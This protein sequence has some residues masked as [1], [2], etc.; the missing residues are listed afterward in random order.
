M[1]ATTV[2]EILD[3]ARRLESL[4]AEHCE[5]LAERSADGNVR[6]LAA[7]L[8]RHYRRLAG[9]LEAFSQEAY[10]R[11]C[12]VPIPYGP[13]ATDFRRLLD[14]DLPADATS[15]EVLDTAMRMDKGLTRLYRQVLQQQV[16]AEVR[17][18]FE[19][20]VRFE[21]ADE[22]ELQKLRAIGVA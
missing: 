3:R 6:F 17:E 15:E 4:V 20:L 8:G 2:A 9:I 12:A 5:S 10:R 19:C 1:N 11:V 16:A 22:A 21:Q 14:V 18:L 7:Y 13:Q